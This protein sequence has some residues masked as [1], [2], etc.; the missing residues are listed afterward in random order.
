M[1]SFYLTSNDN[2]EIYCVDFCEN[3]KNPILILQICHGM[4]EHI[5]R[6][7]NFA[8][9]L[10]SNG[11]K[12]FG[13]DNRGHGESV[14]NELY[15]HISDENGD[16]KTVSDVLLLNEYIRE[17]FPNKKIILMGHSMGSMIVRSF[18]NYHSDKIDGAII[19]GTCGVYSAKHKISSLLGKFLCSIGGKRKKYE[20]INRLAFKSYNSKIENKKT[21]FD[22]LTRDEKE[23]DKY[24]LDKNCGFLCTNAFFVDLINLIKD[25]SS[26]ENI[27]KIRKELS[28]LFIAGKMDPVGEYG[29]GVLKS[30]KLYKDAGIKNTKIN[31]YDG[32]RHEILN[33]IG[34]EEVYSDIIKFL[35]IV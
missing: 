25:I 4:A 1:K 3:L 27:S 10:E 12:A 31:L 5:K 23:I 30:Y 19:C 26:K 24:I 34:K 28:I 35:N 18:L 8:K 9:F 7:K 16:K 32:M 11:I 6:Y 33:E 17:N 15:G 13:M 14:D 21:E 2:K 29:K 22:W 20:F